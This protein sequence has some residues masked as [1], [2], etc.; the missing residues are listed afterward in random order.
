MVTYFIVPKKNN[1]EGWD[2]RARIS[3]ESKVVE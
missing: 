1:E 3:K 2:E